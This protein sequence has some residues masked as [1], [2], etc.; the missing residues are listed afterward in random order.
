[1]FKN[2]LKTALRHILKYKS[3]SLINITGL[4]LGLMCLILIFSWIQ[5]ERSY[6]TFHYNADCLFRVAF[7]NET[8]DFFGYY[9][10]GPLASHLQDVVP[11]ITHATNY[12]EMQFKLSKMDKG[13]FCIG[14]YVDHDFFDMFSFPL[15]RGDANTLFA[16]PASV[17][18]TEKTAIKFFGQLNPV[19]QSVKLNDGQRLTISGVLKDIPE[20]SHMQFDFVMPFESAPDWMKRW[21]LK[22]STTYVMLSSNSNVEHVDHKIYGVMNQHNPEWKN[23]LFLNSMNKSHL[24]NLGGGGLITYVYIFTAMGIVILLMAC[25]NFINLTTAYSERR[26]KEIG[27]R[28]AI[29]SSRYSIM[30]QFLGEAMLFALFSMMIAIFFIELVSPHLN[31]VLGKSIRISLSP[32]FLLSFAGLTIITGVGAGLLPAIYFSRQQPVRMLSNSS[33]TGT[34]GRSAIL[35]KTLV[36]VQYTLSILFLI[37]LFSI[38]TQLRYIQ[39]KELGYTRD[40]VIMV[41]TRGAFNQKAPFIKEQF[42]RHTSIR[43]VTVSGNE[44]L[45]LRGMGS[46]PIEWPTKNTDEVVEAGFN[47]VDSDFISTLGMKLAHGRFFSEAFETDV[48]DAFV[49]NETAVKRMGFSD[50][51][52]REI[53][54]NQGPFKRTGHIIGVVKDFHAG[55]LHQTMSPIVMMYSDRANYMFIRVESQSIKKT[56]AFIQNTIKAHIPDDPFYYEFLDEKI[57]NQYGIEQLTSRL[58]FTLTVLMLVIS[59]L[60]LFGLTSFSMQ[61]RKKEI[62]VRKVFGATVSSLLCLLGSDFTK[63]ILL[64]TIIAWPIAYYAVST[65]L[66]SF[67]YRINLTIWPFLLAGFLA[68]FIAFLTISFQTIRAAT[69]NPVESLRYE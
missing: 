63:W 67:A 29:G 22:C 62:G 19:G 56:L 38:H 6:D 11:E 61:C 21:D 55:S 8:R 28:K 58:T 2:Y 39:S 52:G 41:H 65:W 54:I 23:I 43:G 59:S 25:I 45:S 14:C 64:A 32:V 33:Y 17:V 36:V 44:L 46:G 34:G 12:S 3:L 66:Q 20:N 51:I 53:T 15:L 42:L 27:M 50:P 68:L 7:T 35:R 37:C 16:N 10:P 5:Y 9:Q 40:S 24:Y 18:L 57:A 31:H 30:F 60:G 49:V 1:V 48:Y 69:A 47:M 13:F 26:T 4:V